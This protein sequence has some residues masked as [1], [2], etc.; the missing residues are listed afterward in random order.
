MT[1]LRAFSESICYIDEERSSHHVMEDN[2]ASC[3]IKELQSKMDHHDELPEQ[4]SLQAHSQLAEQLHRLQAIEKISAIIAQ[5]SDI[6]SMLHDV[7]QQILTI[8][9]CDRSWLLYPC[10]PTAATWKVPMECS[11]Q[12]WPGAGILDDLPMTDELA[13]IFHTVLHADGPITFDRVTDQNFANSDFTQKFSIQSQMLICLQPKIGKPWILGIHHCASL[14][15]ISLHEQATFWAIANRIADSLSSLLMLQ[16]LTESEARFRVLMENAPEAIFVLDSEQLTLLQVNDKLSELCGISRAQLLKT[17]LSSILTQQPTLQQAIEECVAGKTPCVEL[18]F[19]NHQQKKLVVEVRLVKLPASQKSLIRGSITDITARKQEEVQLRKL[20]S[21]LQQTGDAI[22]ITDKDGFIEYVNPAFEQITGY[23]AAVAIGKRPSLLRSQ[24]HDKA[25]YQNLWRTISAGQIYAD[26]IINRKFNGSLYYEEKT[27]SPLKDA[28]GNI[29]HYISSGRDITERMELQQRMQYLAHH[30]I[31]TDLPNRALF[32]DRLEQALSHA[33][34]N[35]SMLA[36]MF[37]DLDRFKN[38]NDTLGHDVGDRVLKKAAKRLSKQLRASDS[39][40]RLGGDEFAILLENIESIENAKG[41][42]QGL[43][44]CFSKAFTINKRELFVTTSLGI[45]IFPSDGD[46]ANQLL[47]NADIAMYQAK[48]LGKDTYQCYYKEMNELAD[49]HFTLESEL[50]HA[51]EKDEFRLHYQ[52]KIDLH[53]QQIIG[54]E[55]LLRWQHPT[56]GLIPPDEFIPLLEET[57][58]IVAVGEWTLATA[59]QHLKQW[60]AEGLQPGSI[61]INLSARQFTSSGLEKRLI[62]IIDLYQIPHQLIEIEIT[63]SLLIKNQATAERILNHFRQQGITLALDDFGTG[64]SSLSYLKRFP[65]DV[66]KIDQSFIADLPGDDGDSALVNSIIAMAQALKLTTVAEGIESPQQ[67]QHL[68]QKGCD[69]G[70]GY[71]FSRPLEPQA[72]THYL[73]V[74]KEKSMC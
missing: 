6:N 53:T 41:V 29:T 62:E 1:F 71:L 45:S 15:K 5:A 60:L 16:D 38:I 18:N 64:Y 31:L 21:A 48:K 32:F 7:L 56:L 30:D 22:S 68:Q 28:E 37:L 3:Y 26:I 57:G 63:E 67:Q 27:I 36:V 10:D 54:S 33:V 55:I 52:P 58:M 42:A 49:K 73:Q 24:R 46:N 34:R 14:K 9:G 17:G 44:S 74:N 50:H 66:I 65:I 2:R 20:S 13:K 23:V 69:I 51:L 25:F 70:Q 19:T 11:R 59:C 40:A 72:F 12:E 35:N 4:A 8:L 43:V 39:I 61:A 47:K